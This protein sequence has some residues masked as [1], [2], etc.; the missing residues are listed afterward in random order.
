MLGEF[1]CEGIPPAPQGQPQIEITF[2][3]DSNGI[4]KEGAEH[5]GIG[6]NEKITTTIDKDRLTE[7]QNEQNIEEVEQ[8]AVR[9]KH[10]RRVNAKDV[11]SL[12]S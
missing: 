3:T 11:F 6:R 10:W 2:W 5:K 7:E 4:L 9:I 8:I 1:E 12:I